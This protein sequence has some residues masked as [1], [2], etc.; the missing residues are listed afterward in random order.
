MR[1]S[2]SR[3]LIV[4]RIGAGRSEISNRRHMK[5]KPRGRPS[6]G[7]MVHCRVSVLPDGFTT[8]SPSLKVRKRTMP[9]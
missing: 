7:S 8:S 9:R 3:D 1:G 6:F 2:S 4:R 5:A